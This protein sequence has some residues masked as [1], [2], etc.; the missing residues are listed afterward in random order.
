MDFIINIIIIDFLNFKKKDS[1]YNSM[2]IKL[3]TKL[4]NS[5]FYY[6]LNIFNSY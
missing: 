5:C 4:Y 6:L 1:Y 3:K 2:L